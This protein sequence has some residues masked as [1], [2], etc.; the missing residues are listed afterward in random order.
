[1]PLPRLL[2]ISELWGAAGLTA[3]AGIAGWVE[4]LLLRAKLNARIGRTGLPA[5]YVA[6]LWA[7]A[8]GAAAAAWA[9]KLAAPPLHPALTAVVVLTPYGVVF[10]GA[11]LALGVGEASAAAARILRRR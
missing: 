5:P 2:G 7:S 10:F 3:S 9:A 11:T 6:K 4:M 1:V 8:A